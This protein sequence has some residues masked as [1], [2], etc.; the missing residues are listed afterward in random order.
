MIISLLQRSTDL[1]PPATATATHFAHS[2]H[3]QVT[4]VRISFI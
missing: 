3:S 4:I 2:L 1:I